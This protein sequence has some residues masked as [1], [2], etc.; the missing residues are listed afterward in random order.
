MRVL[1]PST[2][3]RL[4]AGAP[5]NANTLLAKA[6]SPEAKSILLTSRLRP[7]EFSVQTRNSAIR[8]AELLRARYTLPQRVSADVD[9][10]RK[11]NA[12]ARLAAQ[13]RKRVVFILHGIRDNGDFANH[14]RDLIVART[15]E[16]PDSIDIITDKYDRFALLPFLFYGSR[17]KHVRWFM[18]LYTEA[19]ARS[20]GAAFSFIGHSNGTYVLASALQT[21]KT[22][23]MG[24]VVFAGS[25]VPRRFDWNGLVALPHPRVANLLNVRAAG[26]VVVAVFPRFYELIY[27]F[28]PLGWFRDIGSAGYGGFEQTFGNRH[29]IA[30]VRGGHGAALDE[31]NVEQLVDFALDGH[32]DAKRFVTQPKPDVWVDCLSGVCGLVWLAI[33]GILVGIAILI[34]RIPSL[35]L[36][37]GGAFVYLIVLLFV[38]FNV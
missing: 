30:Y 3:A 35:G 19:L 25:V 16:N 38:F 20:P 12:Q 36:R 22:V 4:A 13:P 11:W 27:R 29:E 18:D 7:A 37:V 21:Y 14:V 15:G 23:T 5:P 34:S 9:T 10:A 31:P 17:Q 26:D 33:V 6:L 2:A 24:N 32:Y 28:F 8:A 1:G